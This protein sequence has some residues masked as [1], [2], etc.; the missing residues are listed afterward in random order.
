MPLSAALAE[1]WRC[2]GHFQQLTMPGVPMRAASPQLGAVRLKMTVRAF[3]LDF[4][5][6][7]VPPESWRRQVTIAST[8]AM[9]DCPGWQYATR[10][11]HRLIL[12]LP[13]PIEISTRADA[14]RWRDLYLRECERLKRDFGLLCDLSCNDWQRCFR[15]PHATRDEQMREP[16][17]THHPRSR[18]RAARPQSIPRR[19]DDWPTAGYGRLYDTLEA[20]SAVLE[21]L[22]D[23]RGD[24]QFWVRC[25]FAAEH[26]SGEVT[27]RGD[28]T[29]TAPRSLGGWG[30]V[31]CWHASCAGRSQDEFR[32]ALVATTAAASG[33]AEAGGVR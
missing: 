2:D 19:T 6:H 30:F 16:T 26:E 32:G 33:L 10:H 14:D 3:D 7:Q 11:G 27:Q 17:H 22:A 8:A 18:K 28:C 9:R 29:L 31:R 15:L 13:E 23:F 1:H 25:P 20:R 24:P 12:P 5:G 21:R 4:E